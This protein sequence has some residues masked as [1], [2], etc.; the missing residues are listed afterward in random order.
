MRHLREFNGQLVRRTIRV[1]D[2]IAVVLKH[3]EKGQPGQRLLLSVDE[4]RAGLKTRS[5]KTTCVPA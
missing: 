5:A 3:P 4:Y 1:G 2:Q